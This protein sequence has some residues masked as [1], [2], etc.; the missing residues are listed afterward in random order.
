[1]MQPLKQVLVIITKIRKKTVASCTIENLV[2]IQIAFSLF[3]I[4]TCTFK[5]GYSLLAM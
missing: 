5:F 1:M 4:C 3:D 2:Y